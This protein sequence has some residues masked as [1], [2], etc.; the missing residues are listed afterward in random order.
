M[1]AGYKLIKK[2]EEKVILNGEAF[3]C[4]LVRS[5]KR[6]HSISVKILCRNH[7]QVNAPFMTSSHVIY[8]FLESKY[9]WI[10]QNQQKAK[11]QNSPKEYQYK[12]GEKFWFLGNSYHLKTQQ[13]N[14]DDVILTDKEHVVNYRKEASIKSLLKKWYRQHALEYFSKRAATLRQKFDFPKIKNIRVRMMKSRWGSC[15]S[16]SEITFNV[17][18]IKAV[19]EVIDYVILHELCHLIQ[20]NHS[21]AFYQLQEEINPHWKTQKKQLDDSSLVFLNC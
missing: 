2:S 20:Q 4:L 1:V 13:D 21:K 19:P 8:N 15:N 17:H 14:K 9:S 12:N 3:S 7:L 6:R 10:K 11:Y 16:R 18:L 5:K